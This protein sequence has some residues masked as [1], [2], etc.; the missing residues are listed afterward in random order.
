LESDR[1]GASRRYGL[2]APKPAEV[3]FSDI[4]FCLA[5]EFHVGSSRRT[6]SKYIGNSSAFAFLDGS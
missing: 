2:Y 1:R 5:E 3:E 4:F 6:P